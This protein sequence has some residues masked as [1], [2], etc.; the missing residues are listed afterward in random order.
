MG[1]SI[2][3]IKHAITAGYLFLL[4]LFIFVVF[5]PSLFSGASIYDV[6]LRLVETPMRWFLYK[7]RSGVLW[8]ERIGCGFPIHAYGEGGLLYPLNWVLYPLLPL[9]LAHDLN[10]M[11]HLMIAAS[12]TF[13]LGRRF[14]GNSAA[15]AV[16][17]VVFAFSGFVWIHMGHS[18]SIQACAWAPWALLALDENKHEIKPVPAVG[19]AFCISI[20]VL[21]RAQYAFY[22]ML[23]LGAYAAWNALSRPR[24]PRLLA[25]L[26][27]TILLGFGMAAA[28]VFP[29][30]EFVMHSNRSAGLEYEAQLLGAVSWSQIFWFFLPLWQESHTQG[31][32]A[33]SIGYVGVTT[34]I[35]M[36]VSLPK[37]R[38]PRYAFWFFLLPVT[39][40]LSMGKDFPLNHFVYQLPGFSLFRSHARWLFVAA[41]AAAMLAGWGTARLLQAVHEPLRRTLLGSLIV[42][43][44]F[45]DLSFFLRPTIHF[46]DRKVQDSIPE[47]V[48]VISGG[49]RYFVRDALNLFIPESRA[50]RLTPPEL[51]RFFT[52]FE[53]M[54]A[55]LGMR[56]GLSSV[57]VYAGLYPRWIYTLL[58]HPDMENLSAMNCEYLFSRDVLQIDGLREIWK[59]DFFRIYRN[60]HSKPRARVALSI[61]P[62]TGA[63]R[64]TD[65][66][67]ADIIPS[68][69]QDEVNIN[70]YS[71]EPAFLVL[72]DTFY[73]GWK[74]YVNGKEEEILRVS[75]W[76]RGVPIPKGAS[77]VVFRYE[78]AS[79]IWG[80]VVSGSALLLS[81][82]L[83]VIGAR[84]R[85]PISRT[86]PEQTH[87]KQGEKG[88]GG[89]GQRGQQ[90][91]R[92][93]GE[94]D[95]VASR[96]QL[97][98]LK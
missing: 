81:A 71:E 30:L 32:S 49:G 10:L 63:E 17:G 66:G 46:L 96:G 11:L 35:L 85:S 65:R 25:L 91:F 61:D 54:H 51:L 44:V 19:L 94:Y 38:T 58:L 31:V 41:L 75:G 40:M 34:G 9:P 5:S 1:P 59:N 33:E 68:R 72:A 89:D 43:V 56:Y 23:L 52:A 18:S 90:V 22:T 27:F 36:F 20:M 82:L 88:G 28:Q 62:R 60:E 77:N 8:T 95:L 7:E 16:S 69:R 92:A 42:L 26:F 84:L 70:A 15:S 86:S 2:A 45:L 93:K 13:F 74:A 50:V 24:S 57:Q 37:I 97:H 87:E 79:F 12:G 80:M 98:A 21:T 73:P 47:A 78:P 29:T 53:G 48:S 14:F 83:L 3:K 39:L 6:D 76:M 55:N 67:E 4:A 64:G